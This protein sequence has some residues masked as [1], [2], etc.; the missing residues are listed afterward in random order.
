LGLH[1][2]LDDQQRGGSG[3]S[4]SGAGSSG[5]LSD[6]GGVDGSGSNIVPPAIIPQ[7][8]PQTGFPTTLIGTTSVPVDP[9]DS[10]GHGSAGFIEQQNSGLASSSGNAGQVGSDDAAQLGNGQLNNVA[11]PQASNAL[12]LALGPAVREAL[13]EALIGLGDWNDADAAADATTSS[14]DGQE[15]VLSAGDVA[16]IDDKKVKN[17]PLNQAPEKLRDA[18]SGD[19]IK[20]M[21]AGTGR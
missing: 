19:I 3:G 14:V 12:N 16:E 7:F 18:M 5:G 8:S 9:F 11:N 15:K 13:A 6:T 17:I 10:E 20:G 2:Y 4:N 1:E 21:P